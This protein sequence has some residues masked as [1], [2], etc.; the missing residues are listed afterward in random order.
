ME[1]Y[2][3]TCK[4]NNKIYIGSTKYT[5]EQRWGDL[6]SSSSHLSRVR[7]N[8]NRPLYNDIKK[9]GKENFILET[10]EII[11]GDRH[12]AYKREDYWIKKYWDLYGE[13]KMYNQ[14]RGSHGNKNWT[15]PHIPKYQQKAAM[16]RKEKYGTSN[17]KMIT[18]E[19]IEK[20]KITRFKKYGRY[21]KPLSKEKKEKHDIEVSNKILDTYTNNIIIGYKNV[22]ILLNQEGYNLTYWI[23]RRLVNGIVSQ[24]NI[25]KYPELEKMKNRFIIL[26]KKK[27]NK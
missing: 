13:E 27:I 4:V 15:V 9:Y 26:N 1:I 2:K 18:K 16:I 14:Y 10:I 5:K 11:N 3:I 21:N 22:Q 6:S 8:D 7:N 17:A 25:K 24:Y 20:A 23:S 19:A 12:E